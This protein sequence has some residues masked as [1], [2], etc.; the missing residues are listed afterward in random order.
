MAAVPIAFLALFYLNN[1]EPSNEQGVKEEVGNVL[2]HVK[3]RRVI[4]LFASTLVTFV[5]LF[6]PLVYYLPIFMYTSFGSSHLLTGATV[7]SASLTSAL[8]FT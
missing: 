6:G 1:P 3:S 8:A 5:V 2:E 4:G 7:A